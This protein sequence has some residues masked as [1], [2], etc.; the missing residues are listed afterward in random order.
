MFRKYCR[1]MAITLVASFLTI[2]TTAAASEPARILMATT[3][4]M[5]P[6]FFSTETIKNAPVSAR[7]TVRSVQELVDGNRIVHNNVIVLYRDKE[8]RVRREHEADPMGNQ[9]ISLSDPQR[10]RV[11]MLHPHN[12][13]AIKLPVASNFTNISQPFIDVSN[14]QSDPGVPRDEL[15]FSSP[16]PEHAQIDVQASV[17]VEPTGG[18]A[19]PGPS[20]MAFSP[21]K[22]TVESLGQDTLDGVRVEGKVRVTTHEAD[23]IGNEKEIIVIKKTWYAPELHMMLRSEEVDPRFGR[24][25]YRAEILSTDEPDPSLFE[26]PKGYQ[27][28]EPST[29]FEVLPS[30]PIHFE[31]A[32]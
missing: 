21:G 9:A 18:H 19:F 13:T 1:A 17:F 32:S 15:N 31:P 7:I 12:K 22:T 6:D 3:P 28:I 5:F 14:L 24:I 16:V 20:I 30:E 10:N 8:G 2:T 29:M 25:I 11:V 26:V 4:D 27:V 23:S